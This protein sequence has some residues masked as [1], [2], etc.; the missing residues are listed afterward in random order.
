MERKDSV[1]VLIG[2]DQAGSSLRLSF[3]NTSVVN[4]WNRIECNPHGAV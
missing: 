1:A 4:S 3:Y 2:A